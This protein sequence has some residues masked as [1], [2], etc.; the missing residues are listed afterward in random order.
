MLDVLLSLEFFQYLLCKDL[1]VVHSR[2]FAQIQED[3]P[4]AHYIYPK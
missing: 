4:V 3:Q 2:K 1:G